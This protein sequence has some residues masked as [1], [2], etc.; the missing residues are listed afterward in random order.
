MKILKFSSLLLVILTLYSC[1]T[2]VKTTKPTNADLS[3]Y[4]TFS[5]LPNAAIEM[6]TN[7]FSTEKVNSMVIQQINDKMMDAGYNLDRDM[8]D[9]LVLVSTKVNKETQTDTDPVYA[10]YGAYNR[11]N[12]RVNNYY[13]NYYYNGY[14][15]YNNVIGYDT[16]TYTYKEG[17]LIIQLVDRK[18]RTTVW[19]GI[20]NTDIYQSNSTAALTQLVN[21]IFKEYPLMK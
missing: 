17:S 15:S 20:S 7:K 18:T 16:D 4:N 13:N 10:T 8:P 14:N 21:D 19:K 3:N 6:P 11:P 1:G 12:V 5:Y 9:L 2:A